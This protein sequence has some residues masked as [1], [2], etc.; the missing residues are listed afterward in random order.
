MGLHG[1]NQRFY[2]FGSFRIDAANHLLLQEGRPV[3]LQPKTFDLL[4]LLVERA[5]EVVGKEEIMT[6]LW[7]G[8]AVEEA[9]LTQNV[10]LLRKILGRGPD[11]GQLIET[12]P[13]RGY[14]FAGVVSESRQPEVETPSPAA[15]EKPD[16]KRPPFLLLLLL[17]PLAA[18][19]IATTFWWKHHA[20]SREETRAPSAAPGPRRAPFALVK[21]SKLT[22]FGKVWRATVSADGKYLA[23]SLYDEREGDSLWVKN[24]PSESTMRIGA[25]T[26]AGY[27][28][29]TFSPDGNYL[30]YASNRNWPCDIY[31]IPVLGGAARRIAAEV[32]SAF[33]LSPDGRQLAFVR[34]RPDGSESALVIAGVDGG[35]R[36]IAE[37][38]EPETFGLKGLNPAWSPDG[39]KI[40]CAASDADGA[41][42]VE[43]TVAEG[44]SRVIS[45]PGWR[46]IDG[47]AW[48]PDGAGWLIAAA[49]KNSDVKQVY[50]VAEAGGAARC[51]TNDLSDY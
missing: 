8:T 21:L 17:L 24:L 4:L 14:K 43:Y 26:K 50:H 35:E 49:E 9:N 38:R 46:T 10:Y 44:A 47:L 25:P 33:A 27:E 2:E 16:R 3:A 13:K 15:D 32:W 30:Y 37:R 1:K 18:F 45:A 22:D 42:L 41:A 28:S 7:P 31:A 6:R 12:I 5:G 39:R 11:G 29:P 19:G 20:D 51:V 23:Y 40:A 34:R 48:L 36:Q